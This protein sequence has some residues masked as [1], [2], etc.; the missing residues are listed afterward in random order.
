MTFGSNG[1]R[2][3][4]TIGSNLAL[5]FLGLPD[6][7]ERYVAETG[8]RDPSKLAAWSQRHFGGV[9]TPAQD[10]LFRA[11]LARKFKR[12]RARKPMSRKAR[13]AIRKAAGI[14]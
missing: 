7:V 8:A 9:L 2:A 14:E 4:K 6:L 12:K 10:G 1:V 13:A 11:A 3:R 5:F